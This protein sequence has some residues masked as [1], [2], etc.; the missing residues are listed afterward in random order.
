MQTRRFGRKGHEVSALGLGCMDMSDFYGARAEAE[1]I[2]TVTRAPTSP[3]AARS[4]PPAGSVRRSTRS[5]LHRRGRVVAVL[6]TALTATACVPSGH[7]A[8]E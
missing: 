8:G 5:L 7:S 3:T 4:H 2:P 1:S 6:G